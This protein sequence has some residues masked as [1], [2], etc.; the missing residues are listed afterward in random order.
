MTEDREFI[1]LVG[2]AAAAAWPLAAHGQQSGLPVIGFL[3][4]SSLEARSEYVAAFHQGLAEAGYAEGRNVR[5]EYRMGGGAKQSIALHGCQFGSA[6]ASVIVAT[7][8]AATAL[9][10][11]AASATIPIIF[12]IG[13]DPVEFG[14]VESLSR[15][16]GNITGVSTLAVGTVA[17]RLQLLHELVP[18]AAKIAFLHNPA[19][20]SFSAVETK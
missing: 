11:K 18:A 3:N 2:G 12:L 14:L 19:N 4:P 7:D 15:P 20:P 17:K 10:A 1:T 5:I 6:E 13:A 9:A 8:G 16:G